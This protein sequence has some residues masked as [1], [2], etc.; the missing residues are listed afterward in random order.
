M[1]DRIPEIRKRLKKKLD[2]FR[3]EHSLSVSYTAAALAMRYGYDLDKAELAGLLHDC[4]RQFDNDMLYEKCLEKGLEVTEDEEKNRILLHA[5]Y[6]S[7]MAAHKYGIE[8]PEILSA[9]TYHTTGK[10]DMSLLEKIIYIAD[11][12]EP[13]RNKADNLEYMR[14][15]AFIDLDKALIEIMT[16]ILYY[17]E[18]THASID[19]QTE[20]AC[21]YYRKDSLAKP[22]KTAP[23]N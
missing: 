5:K 3:Y 4:A 16:G 19:K 15:L 8:D 23:Q 13:R 1:N 6:G 12:I 21:E 17:L 22:E 2:P 20:K 18:K 9:I 11:Y 14:Q 7:Y 10:P